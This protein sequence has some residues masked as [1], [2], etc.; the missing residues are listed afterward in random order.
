MSANKDFSE[1][2]EIATEFLRAVTSE[3]D[4]YTKVKGV[5]KVEG[6][7]AIL[8][9]PSHIQYAK[10]GR[11]P[12]KKP[13]LDPILEWVK[14]EGIKFEKLNEVGTAFAIQASIGLKGTKN[15]VPNAPSFLDES[16]SKYFKEYQLQLGRKLIVQIND[17]VNSIYKQIDLSNIV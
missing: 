14:S 17:E 2:M 3:L 13:P 11:G 12:G 7:K 8:L 5:I 15:F 6:S 9:T 4:P 1:L 10:Y 16:I